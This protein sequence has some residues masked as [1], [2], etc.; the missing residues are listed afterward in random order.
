MTSFFFLIGL[1]KF[2]KKKVRI[3]PE[4]SRN[5]T[6]FYEEVNKTGM[7]LDSL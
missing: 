6:R 7:S 2:M 4:K 5:L 3:L 1:V